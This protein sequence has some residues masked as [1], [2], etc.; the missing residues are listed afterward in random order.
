MNLKLTRP[1]AF[2]DLETTGLITAKDRIV[3]ICIIKI[4]PDGTRTTYN[5][6]VNPG[7]LIPKESSDVHGL[8]AE[9]LADKPTFHNIAKVII[10]LLTGCDIAGHNSNRFDIPL[11]VE[12]L[13]RNGFGFD[14]LK[15]VK[16]V[17]TQIIYHSKVKR[18]LTDA[19]KLYV[20]ENGF[21]DAHDAEADVNATIDVLMGQVDM[22][23]DIGNTVDEIIEYQNNVKPNKN[24]DFAGMFNWDAKGNPI[25][26]FG[27]YKNRDAYTV[28]KGNHN[29]YGWLM[30]ADFP[31]HTKT[32]VTDLY[33]T[34]NK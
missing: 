17:D 16:F 15:D 24:I 12:E 23:D 10:D 28:L 13:L 22:Y 8:T 25:F 27:K 3:Q 4:N 18:R 20:D 7:I 1:L 34:A 2:L 30:N 33:N 9:V 29:Y 21:D 19:Y 6:M 14:F 32:I 26:T 31:Q 5:Q 11:L